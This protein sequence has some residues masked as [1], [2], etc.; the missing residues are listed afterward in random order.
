MELTPG[1]EILIKTRPAWRSFWVFFL[2][3]LLVG[4]GPFLKEDPPLSPATGLIF[5]AIFAL[6][7][8]RRWSDVY[9]LTNRRV[10][11]RGG[12]IER[13]ASDIKLNQVSSVETF[14]GFNLRLV[15]AGHV[16]V[17]SSDP[18]QENIMMYG[19]ADPEAIRARIESLA[20]RVRGESPEQDASEPNA[21]DNK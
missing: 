11:V 5:A 1:E 4:A 10:I 13:G 18:N 3:I 8:L 19:Q 7:I 12:L 17:R 21:E 14:Q 6:I 2:G 15:K 9:I 16:L 20:A